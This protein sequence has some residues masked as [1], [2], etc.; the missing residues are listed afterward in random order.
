MVSNL[1][2]NQV[3]ITLIHRAVRPEVLLIMRRVGT[4]ED[5]SVSVPVMST[6]SERCDPH[7]GALMPGALTWLLERL[8]ATATAVTESPL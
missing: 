2:K 6:T 8:G 1:K 7:S 3:L 4:W 5:D